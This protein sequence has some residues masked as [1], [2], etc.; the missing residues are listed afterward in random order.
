[1]SDVDDQADDAA[2]DD[3]GPEA[4]ADAESGGGPEALVPA[5]PAQRLMAFGIDY[6][7]VIVVFV[8]L[9]ITGMSG[10]LAAAVWVALTLAVQVPIAWGHSP[11]MAALG[12]RALPSTGHGSPGLARAIVRWFVPLAAIG[13]PV[14][15]FRLA[16]ASLVNDAGARPVWVSAVQMLITWGA[17]VVV[18]RGLWSDPRRRGLHDLAAGTLILVSVDDDLDR[19]R[20]RQPR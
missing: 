2:A 9:N 13:T 12:L 10:A 17:V 3:D 18:Y 14:L 1:V 15:V 8:V 16:T 7:I 6:V 4:D 5:G 19:Q 20:Q 11:G